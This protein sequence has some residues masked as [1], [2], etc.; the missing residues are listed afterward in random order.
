[1][2]IML[3]VALLLGGS[4][5]VRDVR[6]DRSYDEPHET[7]SYRRFCEAPDKRT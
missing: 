5:V 3:G 1:M 4:R 7:V 2:A 6:D